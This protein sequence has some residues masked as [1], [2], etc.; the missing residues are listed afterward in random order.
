[1]IA[2]MIKVMIKVMIMIKGG[3]GPGTCPEMILGFL[4][5]QEIP[6]LVHFI[7]HLIKHAILSSHSFYI[8]AY[9]ID[10]QYCPVLPGVGLLVFI[11]LPTAF[12]TQTH[13]TLCP[14]R[15]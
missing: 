6:Y 7:P 15:P 4:K 9:W 8:I 3:P 1:M 10:C 12:E 11:A 13:S 14:Q 5:E 2:V